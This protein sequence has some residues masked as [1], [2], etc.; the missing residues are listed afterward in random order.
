MT[1]T[2]RSPEGSMACWFQSNDWMARASTR[3]RMA[4]VAASVDAA[5][6]NS[7]RKK[8]MLANSRAPISRCP[9]PF[10]K[11]NRLNSGLNRFGSMA[12][13]TTPTA[14]RPVR[15]RVRREMSGRSVGPTARLM[16]L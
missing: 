4:S 9:P 7:S 10:L 15:I 5:V 8:M 6:R 1:T 14:S 12:S 13:A 2:I 11:L 3:C 16:M